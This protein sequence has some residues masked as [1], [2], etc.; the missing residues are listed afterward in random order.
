LVTVLA[1]SGFSHHNDPY[2]AGYLAAHQ[3]LEPLNKEDPVLLITFITPHY[4]HA[5]VV[6]GISFAS[7]KV[8]LIGCSTCGVISMQGACEEGVVVLALHDPSMHV[9]LAMQEGLSVNP[10]ASVE[11]VTE[12]LEQKRSFFQIGRQTTALTFA[13]GVHGMQVIDQAL[14]YATTVF[15]PFCSIVGGG[16]GSLQGGEAPLF[17]QDKTSYDALGMALL[18]SKNPAGVGVRHGWQPFGE[19]MLITRSEGSIIY[20]LDHK[21]AFEAYRERFPDENLTP[22]TFPAHSMAYPLGFVLIDNE[23][24]VRVPRRVLPDGAIECAGTLPGNAVTYTMKGH[25]DSLL[26]AAQ[27]AA[28]QAMAQ[29]GGKPAAAALVIECAS[30]PQLLG[31]QTEIELALVRDV[32]GK[33]TPIIGMYGLGEFAASIAAVNVHHKTIVVYVI[34]HGS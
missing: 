17:M 32:V 31:K 28:Q 7:G 20:Q 25:P 33:N 29:L 26:H 15:G 3:A 30:R 22:E 21:P 24:L 12:Y 8:P 27:T 6:E 5:A 2:E 16:A 4:H 11:R 13:D 23:L 1:G 10:L 14:Q 9:S 34:G 18:V 19:R